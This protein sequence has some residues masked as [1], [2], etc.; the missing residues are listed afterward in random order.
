M[1]VDGNV[2]VRLLNCTIT[3]IVGGQTTTYEGVYAGPASGS[4][5]KPYVEISGG[6]ISAPYGVIELRYARQRSGSNS[7]IKN[8]DLTSTSG[9]AALEIY[10]TDNVTVG[11]SGHPVDI[12]AAD[13]ALFIEGG[14]PSVRYCDIRDGYYS[15]YLVDAS[16]TFDRCYLDGQDDSEADYGVV[17]TGSS[18]PRFTFG[19][20]SG[21]DETEFGLWNDASNTPDLDLWDGENGIHTNW[22][23]NSGSP[24]DGTA[25]L[26]VYAN[27]TPSPSIA[28]DYNWWGDANPTWSNIFYPSGG[29]VDGDPVSSPP[30][31]GRPK[32]VQRNYNSH[33]ELYIS[34]CS[35][36]ARND[37]VTS[38]QL[39]TQLVQR[40]PETV[41]A[42][43]SLYRMQSIMRRRSVSESEFREFFEGVIDDAFVPPQLARVAKAI[44]EQS[45][46]FYGHRDQVIELYRRRAEGADATAKEELEYWYT[47]AK[48]AY[49]DRDIST[50]Q[51]VISRVEESELEYLAAETTTGFPPSRNVGMV[52]RNMLNR[53]MLTDELLRSSHLARSTGSL[54][55]ESLFVSPTPFNPTTTVMYRM[56]NFGSAHLAVYSSTGQLVRTLINEESD[57]GVHRVIWDGSDDS[58]R[59]VAS[60][61]YMVRFSTPNVV[62]TKRVTL[63]R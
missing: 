35:A 19:W 57:V 2:Y 5:Y 63:V 28:F 62:A 51:E 8:V 26:A 59:P 50:L 44:L 7:V 30:T 36:D 45:L 61:V 6:S 4:T 32:P 56:E 33:E 46:K 53:A 14:S 24:V 29:F 48:Y 17:I 1:S 55:D 15:V 20:M 58:N 21:H 34:A 13:G 37:L 42:R 27:F 10:D 38:I 16:P 54:N 12:D 22:Y 41:H 11:A 43:H 39:Y 52:V 31:Y 3:E 9:S 23:D 60:G 18:D 40:Y 25:S 47:V 49:E